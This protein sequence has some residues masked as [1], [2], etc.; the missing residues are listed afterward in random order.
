MSIA[1][2]PLATR[3]TIHEQIR[4]LP[5][6]E[7]FLR[8]LLCSALS[9]APK[10]TLRECC[11]PQAAAFSFLLRQRPDSEPMTEDIAIYLL[12][13]W[14]DVAETQAFALYNAQA[15]RNAVR[16]IQQPTFSDTAF[17]LF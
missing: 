15:F 13:Y 6:D 8:L 10:A 3:E 12:R 17:L 16:A 14:R 5:K 7:S 1:F 9:R 2:S 11:E 4:A